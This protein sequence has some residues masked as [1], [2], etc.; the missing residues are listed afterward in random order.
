MKEI[1]LELAPKVHRSYP[2]L[3]AAVKQA[4]DSL[5]DAEIRDSIYTMYARCEAVITANGM[6]IDY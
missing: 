1:L 6:Y 4:W 5:I 2:R 3:R